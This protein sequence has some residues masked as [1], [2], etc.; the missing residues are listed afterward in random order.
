[1]SFESDESDSLNS[2]KQTRS[3]LVD[4]TVCCTCSAS[5]HEQMLAVGCGHPTKP[6]LSQTTP[7]RPSWRTHI[8][9]VSA[10]L[11]QRQLWTESLCPFSEARHF[12]IR[13]PIINVSCGWAVRG[14]QTESAHLLVNDLSITGQEPMSASCLSLGVAKLHVLLSM[15]WNKRPSSYSH[16]D[17]L[18]PAHTRPQTLPPGVRGK[19]CRFRRLSSVHIYDI[20]Q[21]VSSVH[22]KQL[23]TCRPRKAGLG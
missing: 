12:I 21:S 5:L 6:F 11:Q 18:C 23:A 22:M 16:R 19:D 15:S 8:C 7:T 14:T 3:D 9:P 4:F 20:I 13:P 17:G 2:W 10:L 1:M